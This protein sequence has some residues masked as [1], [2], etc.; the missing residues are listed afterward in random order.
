[1]LA[2]RLVK[3][4]VRFVEVAY[5]GWD[6]HVDNFSRIPE[7]ASKLDQ[8]ASNLLRGLEAEGL[9]ERT[10]VAIVTEFGRTPKI[11]ANSG[12]DHHSQ[13]YSCALAGGGVRGGQIIGKS[14]AAGEKIADGAQRYEPRHFNAT[15]AH[16]LGLDLREIIHSPSGRPFTV[17]AK[18]GKPI[19]Q[20]FS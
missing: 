2:K 10:I 17:A 7:L 18:D 1:M 20:V 8:G 14:D 15:I 6:T 13:A 11:N 16:A 5:G 9:L 4:G 19:P 12:R 3:G